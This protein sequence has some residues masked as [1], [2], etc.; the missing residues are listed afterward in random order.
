MLLRRVLRRRLVRASVETEVIRRVLRRGECYRRRL[1]GACDGKPLAM[2]DDWCAYGHTKIALKC[3]HCQQH[4]WRR[5]SG[6]REP[7]PRLSMHHQHSHLKGQV[8]CLSF[9]PKHYT[10]LCLWIKCATLVV[11]SG[12]YHARRSLKGND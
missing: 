12:H 8:C 1:E 4:W 3:V 10:I 11:A 2:C 6:S 7:F 5:N 9:K